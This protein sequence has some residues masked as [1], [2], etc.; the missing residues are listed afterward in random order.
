MSVS[1]LPLRGGVQFDKRDAGR[2][3]RVSAHPD[4]RTVTLSIWRGDVCVGTH[5][6]D[7]A[8]VP[9][10]IEVLARTLVSPAAL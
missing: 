10:L 9:E 2:A 1:P 5:Q 6:M 7:V 8:D 3:L 4:S